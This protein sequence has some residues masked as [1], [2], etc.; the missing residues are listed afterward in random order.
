MSEH[1][2]DHDVSQETHVKKITAAAR[3]MPSVTRKLS[4]TMSTTAAN[5]TRGTLV[6]GLHVTSSTRARRTTAMSTRDVFHMAKLPAPLITT[7]SAITA[8]KATG[9]SAMS[10]WTHVQMSNVLRT[11]IIP[12][13]L[14]SITLNSVCVYVTITLSAMATPNV[15]Q[16]IHVPTPNV[17]P[18]PHVTT[19]NVNVN[20]DTPVTDAHV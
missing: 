15:F 6:M 12:W 18:T 19:A 10:S 9:L 7:V 5:V 8:T 2:V 20:L 3:C 14:V 16:K 13:W 11:H 4:V 17:I 1:Q